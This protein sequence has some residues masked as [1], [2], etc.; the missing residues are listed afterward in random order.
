MAVNN[1]PEPQLETILLRH[2]QRLSYE[3]IAR[4]LKCPV[5]Q[6]KSRRHY[7]RTLLRE[8]LQEMGVVPGP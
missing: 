2:H 8:R 3:E 4:V 6:L 7:A 1:L 5:P